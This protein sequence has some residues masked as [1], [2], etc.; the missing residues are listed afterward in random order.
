[1]LG[2]FIAASLIVLLVVA[3]VD[4][5]RSYLEESDTELDKALFKGPH[6]MCCGEFRFRQVVVSFDN[7]LL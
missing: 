7:F 4:R 5:N 3:S 2:A 6:T 1:M